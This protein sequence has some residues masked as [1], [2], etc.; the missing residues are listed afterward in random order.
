M[1][2]ICQ[3]NAANQ[4]LSARSNY[5]G[6]QRTSAILDA[7]VEE[8]ACI[9]DIKLRQKAGAAELMIK[10]SLLVSALVAVM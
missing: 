10:I 2:S 8:K 6:D 1:A 5:K 3:E 4:I 7:R 9:D